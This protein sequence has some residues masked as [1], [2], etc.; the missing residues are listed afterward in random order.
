MVGAGDPRVQVLVLCPVDRIHVNVCFHFTGVHA[1]EIGLGVLR[2]N[3]IK[4]RT[5]HYGPLMI[6]RPPAALEEE[7]G[8][9]KDEEK[10]PSRDA[11]HQRKIQ[12]AAVNRVGVVVLVVLC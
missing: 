7:E 9:D 3:A 6:L 12:V 1:P 2:G 8:D 5:I 11:N 10:D 4:V